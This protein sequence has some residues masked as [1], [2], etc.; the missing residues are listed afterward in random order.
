MQA[1]KYTSIFASA[2]KCVVSEEKD[3]YLSK[4]SLDELKKSIPN[5]PSNNEAFM[6]V[7]FPAF[8]ANRV[9]KNDDVIDTKTAL[10]IYQKFINNPTNIE[11]KRHNVVGVIVSAGFTEFGTD[12]PLTYDEVKDLTTPFCVTLGAVIWKVINPEFASMLEDSNDPT[13]DDYLSISASWELGFQDYK[14]VELAKNQ[15]NIS[16]A[17]IISDA[18]EL[19]KL[20]KQLKINGGTGIVD[21]KRI[22]RMPCDEVFPLGIGFTQKP[23]ADV[24]GVAI[25]ANVNAVAEEAH[26]GEHYEN[27]CSCGK[28]LGGCRCTA[29]NKSI[30]IIENGCPECK[31]ALTGTP[32]YDFYFCPKC[33]K[34]IPKGSKSLVIN[35]YGH[36][37][38]Q[39]CGTSSPTAQWTNKPSKINPKLKNDASLEAPK[40][41]ILDV[42]EKNIIQSSEIIS[43]LTKSDVIIERNNTI[44][45]KSIK[46][47]TDEAIK[48]AVASEI[49]IASPI[50][51][52][53]SSE[54]KKGNDAWLTEKTS[55]ENKTKEVESQLA[56]A[57]TK[58]AE[59]EKALAELQNTVASLQKEKADREAV[60][61]FNARMATV[62]EAYEFDEEQTSVI[63]SEIKNLKSDEEFSQWETKA[64]KM[65]KPFKKGEKKGD[66][67]DDKEPDNDA[68]DSK[69]DS[70]A[71]ESTASV[72][73][74]AIDN[75]KK[76]GAVTN[77]INTQTP[78]LKEKYLA[79]FAME[80]FIVTKR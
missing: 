12:K 9:N 20:S 62:T 26:A 64:K 57:S 56:A 36:I 11:H 48:T 45:F 67:A 46:D 74:N 79:A 37:Q 50:A 77:T 16:T 59:T 55:L 10:A 38:C 31:A 72:V 44:M 73:D 68:D 18:S 54:I 15:K 51:E 58:Q 23:A 39:E 32:A 4:A 61:K 13:S 7:A 41:K 66:K 43:Q 47:I 29:K 5:L 3:M 76:D 8:V 71:S 40:N 22:Y 6:P 70:K 49:A 53:L 33:Q 34:D 78:T 2:V 1:F 27:Q 52:L 17:R 60:E 42:K 19:E 21:D 63:A 35:P 69:K 14:I 28:N 75:A 30:H 65:F 24:K 80:N 25:N